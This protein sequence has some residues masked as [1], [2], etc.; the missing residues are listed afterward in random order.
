M[1]TL[2]LLVRA[3][4]GTTAAAHAAGATS[5]IEQA[6]KPIEYSEDLIANTHTSN[7]IVGG[8]EITQ[9][10]RPYLVPVEGYY[11][12]GGSLISPSAV[13]TAAHCMVSEWPGHPA[14]HVD[15][16]RYS[17]KNDTGVK[18]VLLNDTTQCTGDIVYHPKYNQK[19]NFDNDVAIV[20]LPSPITDITPVRLN[21]NKN[22]PKDGDLV[23]VAGW[24]KY[25]NDINE[26]SDIPNGLNLSYV[27]NE[28]CHSNP[29]RMPEQWILDSM[30]CL[31]GEEGKQEC[32]GD[33]GGPAVLYDG[34]DS[35]LQVGIVSWKTRACGNKRFPGVYTRV[36]VVADW[37]TKTVCDRTGELCKGSKT[38]KNSKSRK[39]NKVQVQDYEYNCTNSP[40]YAPTLPQPSKSPTVSP[41]PTITPKP[42]TVT[43][44]PTWYP[45]TSKSGKREKIFV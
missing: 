28:A 23:D 24:G 33:S 26:L 4:L 43:I 34:G 18:R 7:N 5:S 39:S 16:H 22:I 30:L 3:L 38:S 15:F 45:T 2:L 1:P 10:S 40:T 8:D 35:V 41:A 12:C 6:T 29:H 19:G 44:W 42:S 21:T 14:T 36:S 9:G 17:L 32:S 13:L 37:I 20:F 31:A 25:D 27:S 11:F